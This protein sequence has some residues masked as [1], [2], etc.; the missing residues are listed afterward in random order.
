[1]SRNPRPM[2]P[3][4][5]GGV[6]PTTRWV[7]GTDGR[8][9]CGD[10]SGCTSR[11]SWKRSDSPRSSTTRATT[12]CVRSSGGPLGGPPPR[13]LDLG[14]VRPDEDGLLL[15]DTTLAT[16]P[17]AILKMRERGGRRDGVDLV[18]AVVVERHVHE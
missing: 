11:R 5:R 2:G 9:A 1:M 18:V 6:R 3:S 7:G 8:R 15:I 13:L 4:R 12:G 10:A 16:L 14:D 17:L